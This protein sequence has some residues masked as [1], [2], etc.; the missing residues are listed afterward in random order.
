MSDFGW[1]GEVFNFNMFNMFVWFYYSLLISEGNSCLIL[2]FQYSFQS[3]WPPLQESEVIFRGPVRHLKMAKHVQKSA[4]LAILGALGAPSVNLS[5]YS[6]RAGHKLQNKYWNIKI[7]QELASEMKMWS[8]LKMLISP[9]LDKISKFQVHIWN[10]QE[11]LH[12]IDV[13]L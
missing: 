2:M 10:Q 11:I 1:C 4:M 8:N 6:C 3:L 12:K 13:V 7:G 5:S 9:K